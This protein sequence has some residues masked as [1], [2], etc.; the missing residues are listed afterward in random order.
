MS[1]GSRRRLLFLFSSGRAAATPSAS[2]IRIDETPGSVGSLWLQPLGRSSTETLI[3]L[4]MLEIPR[5]PL[6]EGRFRRA[7]FLFLCLFKEKQHK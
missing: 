5:N 7:V 1:P 6:T 2:Q 4:H 3:F